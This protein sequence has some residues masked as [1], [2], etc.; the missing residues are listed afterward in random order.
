MWPL[1]NEAVSAVAAVASSISAIVALIVVWRAP[2]AAARYSEDLRVR[3]ERQNEIRKQKYLIFSELMKARGVQITREAVAAFNLID[4]VFVDSPKVKDAWAELYSAYG[5]F[6]SVHPSIIEEKLLNLLRT[7]AGDIGL[8]DELRSADFER[9]YYPQA[10]AEE[11][12]ARALQQKS[13]I[14]QISPKSA[15]SLFPPPPSK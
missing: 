7:I 15:G 9:Y 3:S 11:D 6:N 1:A 2:I 10:L 4:L 13:L 8:S 12:R 5:R 14:A